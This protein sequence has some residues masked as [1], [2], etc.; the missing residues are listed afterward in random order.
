M[1]H[2]PRPCLL[3]RDHLASLCVQRVHVEFGQPDEKKRG[4][5]KA[6]LFSS[7]S[8]ITWQTFWHSQHR[9]WGTL[10]SVPSASMLPCENVC[11]VDP[12]PRGEEQAGLSG[13]ALLHPLAELDM[14]PLDTNDRKV[15]AQEQHGPGHVA[16]SPS[17]A[18]RCPRA[19]QESPTTGYPALKERVA[20]PQVRPALFKI[21]R[22]QAEVV[23]AG[24]GSP[25]ARP[26]PSCDPHCGV[27]VTVFAPRLSEP[28][29]IVSP[30]DAA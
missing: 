5:E 21:L 15:I 25:V 24:T 22:P 14:H 9:S 2:M 27:L 30:G 1:L 12:R 4:P 3:L 10:A 29:S 20:R 18:R 28:D 26:R 16:T 13:P 8:R 7:W 17:A 23:T 19:H 11:H 6:G